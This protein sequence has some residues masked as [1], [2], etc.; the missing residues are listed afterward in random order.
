MKKL[1]VALTMGIALATIGIHAHAAGPL[2]F[3][4]KLGI[5]KPSGNNNDSGLNISGMLGQNI[6]GNLYWEAEL[7]LNIKDGDF[8]GNTNWS[9]NSLGGYAVYRTSGN[10]QLKTKLGVVYWDDNFDDDTDLS[11]GIG[12]GFKVGSGLIDVEYTRINDYTDYITVGYIF[13]F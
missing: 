10:V 12:L 6:Q 2:Q 9:M 11:A 13:H 3:G 5:V 8:G 7:S 1:W 4:G